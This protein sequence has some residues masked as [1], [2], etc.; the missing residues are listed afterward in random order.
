[1]IRIVKVF[2]S[3]TKWGPLVLHPLLRWT[4]GRNVHRC[5][6]VVGLE[7]HRRPESVGGSGSTECDSLW[8]FPSQHLDAQSPRSSFF[9]PLITQSAAASSFA[10]RIITFVT[11]CQKNKSNITMLIANPC[12]FA[13]MFSQLLRT[14]FL[15]KVEL[16]DVYFPLSPILFKIKPT[17]V[18][19]IRLPFETVYVTG[20]LNRV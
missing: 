13:D 14:F 2:S 1:M 4:E 9:Q 5:A 17:F 6:S 10:E 12:L 18:H 11:S 15:E 3:A 19:I 8:T 20:N 7:V 16:E